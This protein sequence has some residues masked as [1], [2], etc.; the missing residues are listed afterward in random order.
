MTEVHLSH[1]IPS[2]WFKTEHYTILS[3]F[4]TPEN[5][6]PEGVW[7]EECGLFSMVL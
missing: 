5:V 4:L 1:V 3:E 7:C 6:V 2:I